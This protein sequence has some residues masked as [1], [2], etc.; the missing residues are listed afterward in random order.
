MP[1][2]LYTPF[3]AKAGA[4]IGR[5]LEAQ[6]LQRQEAEKNKLIQSAYMGQPGAMEQLY[7]IDPQA[8]AQ[9]EAQKSQREQAKLK[10]AQTE[11]EMARSESD[12]MR[13]IYSENKELFDSTLKEASKME[14]LE[15]AQAHLD[16]VIQQN[17][18]LFE[19]IKTTTLTQERFDQL[20]KAY[21]PRP[22]EKAGVK[23]FQPITIKNVE[24]GEKVLASPTVDPA[25]GQAKLASF[26]IP[27]GYE[28]STETPEEKRAADI[29]AAGLKKIQETKGRN[30][31]ERAQLSMD[32]GI[33]AA[34]SH[35][36][37]QRSLDLLDM[38][39]TGG[40][41]AAQIKAKQYL[42][43]ESADEAELSYNLGVSVLSQLK[44]T[45]GSAFT[46]A[47][48]DRLARLEA[49]LGK[50]IAGN[51]RILEQA[52][53]IALRSANRGIRTAEK[54]GDTD[55]ANDIREA[56]EFSLAPEPEKKPPAARQA[57]AAAPPQAAPAPAPTA[58]AGLQAGGIKFLGFE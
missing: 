18:E 42:G 12:R 48:G 22:G 53:K 43:M 52:K 38:V 14:T 15:Q 24:T 56:L 7:G 25:T 41:D 8:A 36:V 28:M 40:F 30:E 32:R 31:E 27:P 1:Q 37:I 3:L 21:A 10:A 50:S 33:E 55:T 6:G 44:A 17:P 45:F 26:D 19:G 11:E 23:S 51:R 9:L 5:G 47:E 54:R 16:S 46:E 4:A 34:D 39:E 2:Q 13:Q 49:G 35:A 20:K 29:L 58:G 57:P